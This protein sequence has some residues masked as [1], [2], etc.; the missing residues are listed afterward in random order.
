MGRKQQISIT[1]KSIEAEKSTTNTGAKKI[2]K[3]SKHNNNYGF[4]PILLDKQV[5]RAVW[6]EGR[7]DLLLEYYKK[8]RAIKTMSYD[9][10]RNS[11]NY[12]WALAAREPE[13]KCTHSGLPKELI[14]TTVRVLG[15]PTIICSQIVENKETKNFDL[16]DDVV[17]TDRIEKIIEDNDFLQTVLNNDQVPYTMA[18]GDGAYFVNI[19]KELSDYPIIEFIDGR[20]IEYETKANRVI[21]VTSRK[22]YEHEGKNYL[23][24]DKRSTKMAA[25]EGQKEKRMATVEYHLYQIKNDEDPEAVKEVELSTIPELSGL[26][27]LIFTNISEMLAVV[28]MYSFDKEEERGESFFESKLDLFDDFDQ[29]LSMSS[30]STRLSP[31]VDYVPEELVDHDEDGRPILPKRYDRRYYVYPR[32]RNNVGTNVNKVETTQ[33]ELN[34]D[35]FTADQ[36]NILTHILTGW[37]SPSTLGI[38]IAKKDNADAQREKEKV[39]MFTRD[40]LVN[41]QTAI[42]KRLFKV[43]LKVHDYMLNDNESHDYKITVNYPEYG[44][45]TFEA[46]LAYLVPA[47]S[48]GAMSEERYIDELWEDALSKEEKEKEIT[49]LKEKRQS[50]YSMLGAMENVALE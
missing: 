39:T 1:K 12:F 28:T 4:D 36:M 8:S 29:S 24:T 33:P 6:F 44:N 42:L 27:D 10:N 14:N 26:E 48:S 21:S 20:S 50:A 23:L 5:E 19:D 17:N 45:P 7:G 22:Y 43:V 38:D 18:I 34:F 16:K 25:L 40:F 31:P 9:E 2:I 3:G 37:L 47:Y 11:R 13:L 30:L 46:K 49:A 15:I 32:D 41:C 35:K